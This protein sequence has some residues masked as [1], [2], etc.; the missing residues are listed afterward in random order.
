M[1][2]YE[3]TR[4]NIH[5]NTNEIV[6]E[7]VLVLKVGSIFNKVGFYPIRIKVLA[8]L[9]KRYEKEKTIYLRSNLAQ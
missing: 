2:L 5:N 6:G 7:R 4:V 8:I 1:L 3:K 9:A